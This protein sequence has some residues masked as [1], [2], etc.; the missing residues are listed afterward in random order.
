MPARGDLE[1]ILVLGSGPIVIGQACEFDYSGTQAVKALKSLGYRVVL[2]N[3]NP[4]TIMTDP[5]LGDA[6]YIEPM[7]PTIV[8]RI[9]EKERPEAILPTVGGQ[10]ALNLAVALSERGVLEKYNVELIGARIEAVHTAED[11]QRFAAAMRDAGLPVCEGGFAHTVE[12]GEEILEKTGFPAILRPSFTLGGE[13]AAIAYNIE[14]FRDLLARGLDLSPTR[15]VLV[16]R[17]VLGWKEFEL[18]VMRD[19]ADNAVVICSIENLDAMGV[20]T[21]DS[22]TVAPAMTLTDREYQRMRDWAFAVIRAV[23]V[24]TGGSNIQFAVHPQTGE[25]VV[26]EMNPRVSRSSA[27]ASKATGFPI[28]KIAALLAVGMTL[29]EIPND[30]TGETPASFEPTIDY[31]VV[32]IPRWDFAKFP[33]TGPWL[34]TSMKSVG[35]V[36][37][38]GANFKEAL[39]KALRSLDVGIAGLETA[40]GKIEL[41]ADRLIA[42]LR[43]PTWDRIF[44]AR[45]ALMQGI[46]VEEAARLTQIDP[47]FIEQIAQIVGCEQELSRYGVDSLPES[48][49]RKAKSWGF[50][51]LQIGRLIGTDEAKIRARREKLD[52]RPVF[53]QVDTCAAEFEA[54]TPYL[55]STYATRCEAN[56]TDRRKVLI[57]GGGPIRIG[58][59]IEF[60]D[61]CCQA[62]F[63]L[64][65]LGIESI[66]MNCNPETV[67]TDYDTADRLYF[68]P[69]TLEDVLN[70]V[71]VEKPEG[72]IVQFG[73]Q[74]PLNLARRLEEAGVCILGTKPDAID[75]AED[76]ERFGAL[77]NR[78][79]IPQPENG[80]ASS[81]DEALAIAERI[82]YP[83]LL[84]PSY[85]LGGRSMVIAHDPE[86]VTQYLRHAVK[87][88][89]D[90]PVLI[91]RFLEDAVEIDVDA[92]CDGQRV[93]I[94]GILQHVEHAGVHSGD[95]SAVLPP[96]TL[97]EVQ[98][99]TLK[100]YTRS[101]ALAI[102]VHGLLNV[103]YAIK[104]REVYVLE[105]NP[106]ASRTV[107]FISKATGI[108]WANVAAKIMTGVSLLQ[109]GVT[110]EVTP[111]RKF[112]KEVVLPFN[113]FPEEDIILGPEM[114][115]TGEV[116]GVADDL[117]EAFAK[118]ELGAGRM[119]P[120]EGTVFASVN[121]RDKPGLI[122]VIK[123]LHNLGFK[124][125]ATRGTAERLEEAGL[126]AE[127]VFKVNEGRPNVVDYI[128]NGSIQLVI[129]TPLG[130]ASRFD[131]VALR[132]AAKR[133]RI[134]TVTTIPGARALLDGIRAV[135]R[136]P[137]EVRC[138]QAS[139]PAAN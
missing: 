35:E 22:I 80:M 93:I 73:G 94:S 113:R 40:G 27:L 129:N 1:T 116:M 77:I 100:R 106:R 70:V 139:Q 99:K 85:V 87:A 78:L 28:A 115:S 137:L 112:V 68:D 52:V 124:V 133:H 57:L 117:G 84:R 36:M 49:L 102:G 51:D 38:L 9:I 131:E 109:Q 24:E 72:V 67:S 2:V 86:Q 44:H 103:Q 108:A 69:L 83:V 59:G 39:Q 66:L 21:G 89:E 12:E 54:H 45:E 134:P 122:G 104:D 18:E 74:T 58:Q 56:P 23:G 110:R 128:K 33:R 16:E 13:G 138:L 19:R 125:L 60:D 47:W 4:A 101:L 26:V 10:T 6:T 132:R 136:G 97:T 96:H 119:L 130:R 62:A 15:Q 98:I 37:A 90:R 17:S 81:E 32:K 111:D 25:M 127:V 120:E 92:V 71:E 64:K 31:V 50:S 20:H 34:D 79:G 63:A 41:E 61:C 48:L 75:L 7:T 126:P 95:S 121:D 42:R 82:G 55:Y 76:R 135:R 30:I 29:D 107:P 5:A 14:E 11:R 123:A 46:S 88:S 3:S 118:A 105:A 91:D 65:E 8:E 114:K 53:N 43:T